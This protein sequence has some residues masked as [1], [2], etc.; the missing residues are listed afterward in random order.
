MEKH[1]TKNNGRSKCFLSVSPNVNSRFPTV[2]VSLSLSLWSPK[3]KQYICLFHLK[4]K[5]RRPKKDSK[6]K[7]E[8]K[9]D[10]GGGAMK[11]VFGLLTL[12]TVGMI[13]GTQFQFFSFIILHYLLI[14]IYI[15]IYIMI[16]IVYNFHAMFHFLFFTVL[17]QKIWFIHFPSLSNIPICLTLFIIYFFLIIQWVCTILD[18]I[19]I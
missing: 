12:V 1:A 18:L 7:K 13:I 10:M 11:I 16:L 6:R 17:L 19:F 2:A 9:K 8:R 3:S 15:Y 5:H 4:K 14:Y